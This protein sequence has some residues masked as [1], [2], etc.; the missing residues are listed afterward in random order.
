VIPELQGFALIHRST[1]RLLHRALE[2]ITP[3]Q[4]AAPRPGTN[5]ILWIACHVVSVRAGFLRGLGGP[6][7]PSWTKQFPRGGDPAAVTEWPSL[8]QLRATWDEVHAAY[9]E[10][11]EALTAAEVAAATKIPGLDDT[12]MGALGLA[13]LHDCYHVGQIAMARRSL[14]FDR[15]VG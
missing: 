6:A 5:T 3:E 7:G 15:L 10:R 2:G 4:A 11:L 12:L 8:E 13:A 1:H 14:G 9:V